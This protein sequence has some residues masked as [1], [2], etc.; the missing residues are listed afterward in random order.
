MH[1]QSGRTHVVHK[2]FSNRT[3]EICIQID[4]I[5]IA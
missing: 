4:E 5:I 3:F 2:P 1:K